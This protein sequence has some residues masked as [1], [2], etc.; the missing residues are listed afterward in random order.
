[1]TDQCLNLRPA[2]TLLS[3][4]ISRGLLCRGFIHICPRSESTET[5]PHLSSF[6]LKAHKT[7]RNTAGLTAFQTAGGTCYRNIDCHKGRCTCSQCY[8]SHCCSDAFMDSLLG[9]AVI[10][11]QRNGNPTATT[12]RKLLFMLLVASHSARLYHADQHLQPAHIN[13]EL[14]LLRVRCEVFDASVK[15]GGGPAHARR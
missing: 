3:V 9:H 14:A 10:R 12:V 5:R 4:L 7:N 2:I 6:G 8:K 13:T 15:D 1:M 11:L